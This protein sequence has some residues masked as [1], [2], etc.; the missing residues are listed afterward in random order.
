MERF[1]LLKDRAALEPGALVLK[2]D[3]YADFVAA[4]DILARARERAE[5]IVAQAEIER[6]ERRKEGYEAGMAEGREKMAE[7]L[8]E[9]AAASVEQLSGM[10]KDLVDVVMRSLRTILG[11]FDREELA[12]RTVGH[13][14]RLVRDQKRVLLRV[15]EEDAET[16][17]ARVEEIRTRYP[18]IGRVDVTADPGVS[19]G[20]AVLET[21]IGVVDAT[22]E[23]QLALIEESFRRHVEEGRR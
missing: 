13:A 22:L 1:L 5:A 2:R 16:V 12:V 6:E 18:A 21:E 3:A 15:A 20:G 4:E 11:E 8:L 19:P 14:L 10:E 7:R 23:R 17:A 9:V